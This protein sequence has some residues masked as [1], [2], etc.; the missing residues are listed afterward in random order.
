MT[1][2]QRRHSCTH[3]HQLIHHPVTRPFKCQASSIPHHHLVCFFPMVFWTS[4]IRHWISLLN[5]MLMWP[6]LRLCSKLIL[7]PAC[8]SC[9]M[10]HMVS[11]PPSCTTTHLGLIQCILVGLFDSHAS[12]FFSLLFCS[13]FFVSYFIGSISSLSP[14][15]QY[16]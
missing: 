12:F 6:I 4:H 10:S 16:G 7:P 15:L 8:R 9:L 2:H 13:L 5:R 14:P 11:P 3:P 1:V